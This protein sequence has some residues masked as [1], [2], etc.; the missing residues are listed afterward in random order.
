MEGNKHARSLLDQMEQLAEKRS[1]HPI[2]RLFLGLMDCLLGLTPYI[3]M[4]EL[5][6]YVANPHNPDIFISIMKNK[7]IMKWMVVDDE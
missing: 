3:Y 5:Q 2:S 7:D 4:T 1:D 6:R